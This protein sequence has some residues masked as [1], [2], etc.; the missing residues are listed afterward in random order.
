[1]LFFGKRREGLKSKVTK[2]HGF[3]PMAFFFAVIFL[4]GNFWGFE[5]NHEMESGCQKIKK[6]ENDEPKDTHF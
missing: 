5:F 4:R 3:P 2:G 6:G 1:M